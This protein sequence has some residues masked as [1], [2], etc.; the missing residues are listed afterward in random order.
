MI[1]EV[2]K[3]DFK[4]VELL[5][6]FIASMGNSGESF[7]YFKSR[8]ISVIENHLCTVLLLV[9]NEPIG[10]GHLDRDENDVWFG[11]AVSQ[12]FLGQGNGNI[13]IRYL[14]DKADYLKLPEIKLSVDEN[15]VGAIKLYIKYGFK[16]LHEKNGILFFCRK[17]LL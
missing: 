3:T 1:L 5:E 12:A 6:K 13:I 8:P 17:S 14:V 15:N 4:N 2:D 16:K 9:N 10:Y 11:I 7:R